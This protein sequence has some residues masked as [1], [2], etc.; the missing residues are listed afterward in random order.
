ME[1]R[2]AYEKGLKDFADDRE[3]VKE[4]EAI[5]GNE[6]EIEDRFYTELSFGTAGMRG[7]SRGGSFSISMTALHWSGMMLSVPLGTMTSMI[8]FL[9]R[10]RPFC[11][12]ALNRYLIGHI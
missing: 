5:R 7:V 6:K 12:I 9:I 4:L 2:E 11:P 1:I 8:A 10:F 3:T